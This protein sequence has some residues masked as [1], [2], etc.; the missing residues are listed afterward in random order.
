MQMAENIT[1]KKYIFLI[2]GICIF[3]FLVYNCKSKKSIP[4]TP[5]ANPI[6]T[7]NNM[8]SFYAIDLPLIAQ[9]GDKA[10]WAATLQM[11]YTADSSQYSN[12]TTTLPIYL[13]SLK[14]YLIHYKAE[15]YKNVSDPSW[16][17]IKQEL[18]AKNG[19]VT[20]K[21]FTEKFAHVF[22][23]K[24]YQETS[25][26]KWLLVNDPWPVNKGKITALSF[27][28]FLR[29]LN[30]KDKYDE[31]DYST[32]S[33]SNVIKTEPLFNILSSQSLLDGS[34]L[35]YK[36]ATI[37]E[38]KSKTDIKLSGSNAQVLMK[39]LRAS[40]KKFNVSFFKQM[41]IDYQANTDDLNEDIDGLI[42]LNQFNNTASFVD[43]D[44]TKKFSS[45]Y[46]FDGIRLT[47]VN[48][49]ANDIPNISTTIELEDKALKPYFYVSRF[50]NY[51]NSDKAEWDKIKV[52][53]ENSLKKSGILSMLSGNKNLKM[54]KSRSA[55]AQSETNTDID[56]ISY[57][58]LQGGM[59]FSFT[60][61][62]FEEKIVADPYKQLKIKPGKKAL[63]VAD[64]GI[65]FYRLS[66]I[67]IPERDEIVPKD[68]ALAE[69][70]KLPIEQ[71]NI[72]TGVSTDQLKT[73]NSGEVEQNWKIANSTRP[74]FVVA[75]YERYWQATPIPDT[76]AQW[77][78]SSATN[79][80]QVP[81]IYTF[82]RQIN[83]S[84]D[85]EVLSYD[86]GMAMDDDIVNLELIAPNGSVT[87]LTRKFIR[88]T[89]PTAYYLSK[90]IQGEIITSQKGIWKLRAKLNFIDNV[91]G[92]IVSGNIITEW[93]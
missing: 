66:A 46:L 25:N 74:A 35:N 78:S 19:L 24:G 31:V 3:Q 81:G 29:P 53:F 79:A 45:S 5:D 61:G 10:C 41:N 34:K 77:I 18:L 84:K 30:G 20:Y 1:S 64:N 73:L 60:Y 47:F 40:L 59:A 2:I 76:K 63:F 90:P 23:V 87:D 4:T 58:P 65:P 37:I 22:L 43:Y 17:K 26:S 48:F 52:A 57:L 88:S 68:V 92:F 62:P 93:R 12:T 85:F 42:H 16:E 36:P 51:K 75:P 7:N 91:S 39:D 50:E 9:K 13:D 33:S 21:Y 82:E 15:K 69:E 83:I 14:K 8:P 27:N 89:N 55:S 44:K 38:S 28:Q 6:N 71:I 56:D 54:A 70:W 67:S 72:S 32:S 80:T 49:T 11:M 86:F